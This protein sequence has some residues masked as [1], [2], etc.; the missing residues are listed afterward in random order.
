MMLSNTLNTHLEEVDR[1]ATEM[2]DCLTSQP[3][4][5]EGITEQMKAT[6][7]RMG[8]VDEQCPQPC[9]WMPSASF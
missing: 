7:Q 2:Y 4:E 1:T 8:T 6:N 3:T 5:Q 9:R